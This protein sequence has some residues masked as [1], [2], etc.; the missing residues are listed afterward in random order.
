MKGRIFMDLHKEI[1]SIISQR[2]RGRYNVHML[3]WSELGNTYIMIF[4]PSSDN[5]ILMCT[6]KNG[7]WLCLKFYT[8]T[9]CIYIPPS[10]DPT[11]GESGL[12][13]TLLCCKTRETAVLDP[14]LLCT[15]SLPWQNAWKPLVDWCDIIFWLWMQTYQHQHNKQMSCPAMA[16]LLSNT[17]YYKRF[18]PY[19]AFNVLGGLDNEG[20]L[21]LA[22]YGCSRLIFIIVI[23]YFNLKQERDV[24]SHMMPLVPMRGLDIVL[25][26]LDP[27][28]LCHLLITSWSLLAHSCYLPW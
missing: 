25:R 28:L 11:R 4:C 14:N 10:P 21:F 8:F 16:Q 6:I 3:A 1:T 20:V 22:F 9:F 12:W 26:V 15:F 27:H 24:F 23:F 17:L 2:K 5:L 7:S 19:Y 13:A 18:F